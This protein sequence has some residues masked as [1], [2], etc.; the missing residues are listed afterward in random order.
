MCEGWSLR[1][2]IF[3]IDLTPYTTTEDD[4]A[5]RVTFHTTDN[6]CGPGVAGGAGVMLD[7][8]Y[9]EGYVSPVERTS[10]GSI[11]AMYR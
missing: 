1:A 9:L 3:G 5:F 6:G 7:D 10:W 11:K 4:F 2:L 8:V